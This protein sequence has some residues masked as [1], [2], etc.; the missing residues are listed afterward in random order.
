MF[1]R[2]WGIASDD[3]VF[4]GGFEIFF[5]LLWLCFVLLAYLLENV[6][7]PNDCG[8]SY[9]KLKE[10][11]ISSMV[12]QGVIFVTAVIIVIFSALGTLKNDVPRR[13]IKHVLYFRCFLFIPELILAI[14]GGYYISS[15][16]LLSLSTCPSFIKASC[17]F[18]V[19]ASFV[20]L[21]VTLVIV[22][23]IFDP[24]G[25]SQHLRN[26][27]GRSTESIVDATKYRQRAERSNLWETRLRVIC[28]CCL[29]DTDDNRNALKDV[30]QLL[31][32][33]FETDMDIVP[34]DIAAAL[35]L[36]QRK[37]E[38]LITD[39]PIRSPEPTIN[40]PV[41]PLPWMTASNMYY[42]S[43]Y[44][45][46]I[47]GWPLYCYIHPFT[48]PCHLLSK[49]SCC[50]SPPSDSVVG[51]NGCGCNMVGLKTLLNL[52]NVQLLHC[53][54]SNL[55]FKSPFFVAVD[56]DAQAIII[57]VRGT[58]SFL[59]AITDVTA[60]CELLFKDGDNF[61]STPKRREG[62]REFYDDEVPKDVHYSGHR[63]MVT[64]AENLLLYFRQTQLLIRARESRPGYK[65][66]TTGHSLGAGIAAILALKL[67]REFAHCDSRPEVQC[68][69]FSPP[70]GCLSKAAVKLSLDCTLSVVVDLDFIPRLSYHT[71]ERLKQDLLREIEKSDEP[72]FEILAKGCWSALGRC[73]VDCC[74]GERADLGNPG[75]ESQEHFNQN[76]LNVGSTVLYTE[77]HGRL[78][79]GPET[80][81]GDSLRSQPRL[82][83]AGQI[84]LLK[85]PGPGIVHGKWVGPEHFQEIIVGTTMMT[86]HLPDRVF[87]V[88]K[89]YEETQRTG[90]N[91]V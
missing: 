29:S 20:V 39:L 17:L 80:G 8:D 61:L 78:N 12:L 27:R 65:I 7:N 59:D 85:E 44:A 71:F 49:V 28:C 4:P 36:L 37:Q 24:L 42:Y 56:D 9:G 26:Q 18:G 62:P 58:M 81:D 51:D 75:R 33:M 16:D 66:V 47:Y 45:L 90:L 31:S 19:I 60:S 73:A 41:K 40:G 68:F 54:F 34:S 21:F 13:P 88:V 30:S 55:I 43:K 6:R 48:G 53:S 74:G 77:E 2:R 38:S 22:F 11:L 32:E 70:G 69:A 79:A 25:A 91:L 72:K 67:R 5:R 87:H 57:S 84:L 76:L 10:F 35:V 86:D 89:N 83:P 63:G 52:P 82:Y 3:F 64:A 50:S 46:A 23:I 15:S 14:Y 1:G